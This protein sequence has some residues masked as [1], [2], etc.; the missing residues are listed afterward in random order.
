MGS[1]KEGRKNTGLYW[2]FLEKL[3]FKENKNTL[4]ILEY[5]GDK[6]L[7]TGIL[8]NILENILDYTG[9]FLKKTSGHPE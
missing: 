3:C 4:N 2:N 1:T 5:T 8:L 9:T 7:G 6:N